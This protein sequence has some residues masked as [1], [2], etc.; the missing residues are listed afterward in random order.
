MA[1]LHVRN[2][3]DDL[4]AQIR[5]LAQTR[6]RSMS[7]EI[8]VLLQGALAQERSRQKQAELLAE[9]RRHRYTY[10]KN[11]RVLDSVSLLR[12]DRAR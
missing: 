11:K 1:I 4:Y 9:I 2:I 3:P 8:I 6:N 5:S 10:P 7:A 12:E